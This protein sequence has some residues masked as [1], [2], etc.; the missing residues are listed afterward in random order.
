VSIVYAGGTVD[1]SVHEKNHDGTLTELHRASGGP[2]GGTN[3]DDNYI[4]WLTTM[5]REDAIKR[6]KSEVMRDYFDL[7]REFEIKKRSVLPE[8]KNDHF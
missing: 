6:L 8:T 4:A 3:V 5:F 7:L 1:V 2:L